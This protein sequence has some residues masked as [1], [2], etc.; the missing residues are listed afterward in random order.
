MAS[1]YVVSLTEPQRHRLDALTRRGTSNAR[2]IT[3][4]RI[5][6]LVDASDDGP[7]WPDA[8]VAEA[9][10]VSALTVARVRKRFCAGGLEAAVRP[11]APV[12]AGGRPPKK[13]DGA[14]EAHLIALA[15]SAPPEGRARWT[16]RLL[17]DRFGA[18]GVEAGWIERPVSR[19]TV[20]QALKKRTPPTS[21]EGVGDPPGGLR[22]VRRRPR[23]RARRLRRAARPRPAGRLP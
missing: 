9:V 6:P 19:E 23:A 13:L 14:A 4:A 7:A 21:L 20:R 10:G 15:C 1:K 17:T 2:A 12:G 5:L 16:V 3:H 18:L 8:L 22:V 11:R